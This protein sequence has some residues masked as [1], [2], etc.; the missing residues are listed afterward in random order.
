M[1]CNV[2]DTPLMKAPGIGLY[3]PDLECDSHEGKEEGVLQ[4]ID[5]FEIKRR[6]RDGKAY[7]GMPRASLVEMRVKCEAEC[8]RTEAIWRVTRT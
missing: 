8:K 3:C 4:A 1:H 7:A 6:Q 5:Q 2:C